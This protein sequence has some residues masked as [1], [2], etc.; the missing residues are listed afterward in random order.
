MIRR[1][2]ATLGIAT[3]M[4]AGTT[5]AHAAT[6]TTYREANV[7][8]RGANFDGVFGTCDYK[9]QNHGTRVWCDRDQE[10]VLRYHVGR[11]LMLEGEYIYSQC[12]GANI[13][14]FGGSGETNVTRNGSKVRVYIDGTFN[15]IVH[16][17]WRKFVIAQ[18]TE[19]TEPV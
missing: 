2:I 15:G 9:K 6:V 11:P 14:R 10:L 5:T 13:E 19:I 16:R 8:T 18:D 7:G 12:V 3:V 4:L 17:V 1:L